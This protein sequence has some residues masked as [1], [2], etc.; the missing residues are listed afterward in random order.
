MI[1]A[2]V[3]DT[4]PKIEAVAMLHV[5]VRLETGSISITSGP[6]NAAADEFHITVRGVG[7]HGAAPHK[8]QDTIPCAAA[9]VL[10]LQNIAA[11]ETDP[12]A[13]VVVTVG[14]IAGGYRN[15]VI[16]DSVTLSGTV[17]TTDP[18][19][20]AQ[21]ETRIRRIMDGIAEAYGVSAELSVIYGYPPVINDAGLAEAFTHHVRGSTPITVHALAPTMG[22]EDFAYFAQRVPGLLVRLGVRNEAA[23]AIHSAHS[24]RFRLDEGAI[25]VG[26]ATLVAFAQGVGSGAVPLNERG[27]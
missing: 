4:D 19:V 2:G 7:G 18:D 3:M 15:N 13:S 25:P 27:T 26:I 8:A 21:M 9:L 12:L 5:D 14:T 17:R 16:A 11:R 6:V 23:G 22:A 24:S 10:A 20:R 1:E